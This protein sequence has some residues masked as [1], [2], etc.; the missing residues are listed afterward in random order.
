MAY[1]RT[2]KMPVRCTDFYQFEK[3]IIQGRIIWE[4]KNF[5]KL[6]VTIKIRCGL[7]KPT[8]T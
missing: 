5:L 7:F 3:A 6:E 8:I 4:N 2:N 1:R